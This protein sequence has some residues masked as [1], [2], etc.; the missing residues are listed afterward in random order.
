MRAHRITDP[1]DLHRLFRAYR[2]HGGVGWLFRG[3]AD[4][5]WP[6]IPKAAR[7]E[8][9]NGRDLGRFNAWRQ[10]AF[11]YGPLPENDWECLAVAQHYGLATRLLDWSLN[12][13]VATY[14]AV[15]DQA[16]RDGAVYCFSPD[17]FVDCKI[18][19]LDAPL[20][21]IAVFIPRAL[22]QRVS[23]QAG[24]FTVHAD[25]TR[26]IAVQELEAPLS[27]PNLIRIEIPSELKR[28]VRE[29][30]ADYGIHAHGI[31]PDLDGLSRHIN[32]ETSEFVRRR[33][34]RAETAD[35]APAR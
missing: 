15:I 26:P 9:N 23:R 4:V 34:L 12:P 25:P 11:A 13:L 24:V 19:P 21:R 18:L 3:Q 35:L 22:D 7:A 33:E 27:G 5:S 8:F 2:S 28:R 32:W 14:F 10:L 16:E 30:L 20:D 17:C 31:F 29:M 1:I 6:L